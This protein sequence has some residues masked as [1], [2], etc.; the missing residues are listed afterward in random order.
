[1]V[2]SEALAVLGGSAALVT[3]LLGPSADYV[4]RGLQL[5]TEARIT[6][7]KAIFANA[8]SKLG[9][10]LD[11]EG[12]VPPRLLKE[13]LEEGSY[14]DNAIGVEYF[15]GILA[16]GRTGSGEDD[17]GV[18]WARLVADLSSYTIRAHYV[19]YAL[20]AREFDGESISDVSE[21]DRFRVW[22][23]LD[24]FAVAI[25]P[26]DDDDQRFLT[27]T[28]A[29]SELD[30]LSLLTLASSATQADE[31]EPYEV[32]GTPTLP[33]SELFLWAM[34]EG[35]SARSSRLFTLMDSI[36]DIPE[37]RLPAA[38]RSIR[39]ADSLRRTGPAVDLRSSAQDVRS[40]SAPRP[41]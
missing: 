10:R 27:V 14:W 25:G 32:V 22:V 3:K 41:R 2:D 20:F 39:S 36:P 15:G 38:V 16:S 18:A 35:Q 24:E 33:G 6:N 34:G 5:W 8:E 9:P 12:A 13:M 7:V 28:H 4:G 19:L 17:R 23:D 11:T 1:M 40:G 37:I 21:M 26:E 31:D 30:R 29:I